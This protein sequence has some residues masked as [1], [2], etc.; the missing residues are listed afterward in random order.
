MSY[1][2]CRSPLFPSADTEP[3]WHFQGGNYRWF[4]LGTSAF[5]RVPVNA[6]TD[7]LWQLWAVCRLWAHILIRR[8]IRF[9]E[10]WLDNCHSGMDHE[11]EVSVPHFLFIFKWAIHTRNWIQRYLP[12]DFYVNIPPRRLEEIPH[13]CSAVWEMYISFV[14][15]FSKQITTYLFF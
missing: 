9:V 2:P 12:N 7:K 5:W 15:D 3:A 14:C 13:F 6:L 8:I 4:A 11:E 10:F 1:S